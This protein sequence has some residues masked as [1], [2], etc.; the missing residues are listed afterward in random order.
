MGLCVSVVRCCLRGS[1][2]SS[3]GCAPAVAGSCGASSPALLGSEALGRTG[4]LGTELEDNLVEMTWNGQRS[5]VPLVSVFSFGHVFTSGE[6][7]AEQ[8]SAAPAG[9]QPPLL[10]GSRRSSCK[11]KFTARTRTE[12]REAGTW[13]RPALRPAAPASALIG[14]EVLLLPTP[15][16]CPLS[17]N[18][19]SS[20]PFPRH[21]P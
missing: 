3:A 17:R 16:L 12:P 11:D 8:S 5:L 14:G 19:V 10:H 7:A 20:S 13:E 6:A 2:S 21:R 18:V 4:G 15:Q 1:S 9:P